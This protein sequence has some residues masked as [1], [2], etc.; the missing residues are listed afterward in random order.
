M[1]LKR[2]GVLCVWCEDLKLNK[3]GLLSLG[4]YWCW[5]Y[6]FRKLVSP[7][8]PHM[9]AQFTFGKSLSNAIDVDKWVLG[10]SEH[11]ASHHTKNHSG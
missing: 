8:L 11:A 9:V 3:I 2:T 5:F 4:E 10:K 6:G 7:A 1:V